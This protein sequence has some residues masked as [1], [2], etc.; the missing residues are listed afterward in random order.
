MKINIFLD[1]E[2]FPED[3]KWLELPGVKWVIVRTAL[4]FK[5]VVISEGLENIGIIS[6]DHDINDWSG[7]DHDRE[8]TG[9]T[10]LKWLCNLITTY[11]IP[12]CI[13][14]TQNPIGRSNME[15]YYTNYLNYIDDIS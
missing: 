7:P 14:H 6:F 11:K 3:I 12:E 10:L 13:F 2:R 9:Y 8:V 5:D 15:S 1:D 4:D